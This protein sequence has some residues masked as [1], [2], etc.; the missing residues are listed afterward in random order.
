MTFSCADALAEV[1][2][3]YSSMPLETRS[4]KTINLKNLLLL[5]GEGLKSA[6]AILAAFKDAKK[7]EDGEAA[8]FEMVDKLR[9][10]LLLVADKP[11]ELKKEMADWPLA[12]FLQAVDAWQE[13]TELGE[14]QHSES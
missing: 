10:L 2:K 14:A 3:D 13:A 12:M 7:G 8:A 4:G 9:D 5:P 1:E 11:A 6:R